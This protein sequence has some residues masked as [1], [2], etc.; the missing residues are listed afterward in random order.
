MQIRL[1]PDIEECARAVR[2]P[3][4]V[5]EFLARFPEVPPDLRDEPVLGEY[6]R[7]FGLVLRVA[8]LALRVVAIE[9][10]V[11]TVIFALFARPIASAFTGD[12]AVIATA[13]RLLYVAAAFQIFDA[14]NIVARCA[15]RG[16][17][18]VRYAAV[19]GVLTSWLCT[20]TFA[21]VLGHQLRLGAFGGRHARLCNN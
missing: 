16:A 8:H 19:V 3:M 6:V 9:A 21:W 1:S 14:A 17:G 13:A 5:D 11:F 12:P 18:D 15:L 20:P 2:T 10:A 4:T 7:A